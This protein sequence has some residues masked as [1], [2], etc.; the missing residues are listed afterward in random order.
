MSAP[1]LMDSRVAPQKVERTLEI[2]A[3]FR[4]AVRHDQRNARTRSLA[5]GAVFN[6]LHGPVLFRP[7]WL[8]SCDQPA[9]TLTVPSG[10]AQPN[11]L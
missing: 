9:S 8:L 2:P 5:L 6:A 10:D 7:F 1:Q 3:G 11:P 4:A